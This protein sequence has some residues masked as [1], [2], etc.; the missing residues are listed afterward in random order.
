MKQLWML[1]N[2]L[3]ERST[4]ETGP[5]FAAAL[6]AAGCDVS[7]HSFDPRGRKLAG[8][9]PNLADRPVMAYGSYAFVRHVLS[10]AA[11]V[12]PRPGSYM[13]IENLS[14]HRFA[15]YLGDLLLNDDFH[16]LPFGELK[17]RPPPT[18]DL[19]VRPDRVTKSFTG[20]QIKADTFEYEMSCLD[21]LSGVGPEELVVI[22]SAKP[23]DL[24]CRY[25][26][27][28]GRVVA[29]STYGWAEG[30]V[31]STATDARC[32]EIA[33]EVA[34]RDW[35]P[36]TVYT[37]DVALSGGRGKVVELNSFSCSGLYACD[38]VAVAEAVTACVADEFGML[39]D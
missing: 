22:A 13:Q 3:L 5:T 15:A 25:V 1:D 14:F 35:Q 9:L 31:P 34:R 7:Q 36:D 17:R 8:E 29:K 21:R 33:R 12:V 16:I 18:T 11:P 23:I 37:C 10:N 39:Q 19:F 38:T 28:D 24:E 4:P 6:A 27:A 26:I 2:Y 20:F 32:D 30:F